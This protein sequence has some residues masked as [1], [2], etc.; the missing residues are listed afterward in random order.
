MNDSEADE[1]VRL[2]VLLLLRGGRDV[3]VCCEWVHVCVFFLCVFVLLH[4]GLG[5][6]KP[7]S[8]NPRDFICL[9][10]MYSCLCSCLFL[11]AHICACVCTYMWKPEANLG[12]SSSVASPPTPLLKKV[13]SLALSLPCKLGWLASELQGSA[14]THFSM[15][16][17]QACVT[18]TRE[19][20]QQ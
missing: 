11:C 10:V 20:A 9:Y 13:V 3:C 5:K 18:G 1:W 8:L 19:M 2:W 16:G 6:G 4:K 15:M 17:L 12:C 14:W 7:K